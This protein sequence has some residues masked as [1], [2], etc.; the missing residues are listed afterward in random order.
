MDGEISETLEIVFIVEGEPTPRSA[1]LPGAL[2]VGEVIVHLQGELGGTD[3]EE[4]SLED[5]EA[6]LIAE[7]LLAEVLAG[8]FKV[9][10]LSRKGAVEVTVT[11]NG[12][13]VSKPFRPNATIRKITRWAISPEGLKLEGDA[14]DFQLKLG[15]DI[16]P[17]DQHLGQITKGAKAVSLTLVFKVKPQG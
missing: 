8:E 17:P 9:L 4:L 10:H 16:L 3:L 6:A 12:R 5:A 7:Q 14:A 13:S 15:A 1:K 11:Y 2:A